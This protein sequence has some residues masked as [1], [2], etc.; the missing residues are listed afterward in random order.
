MAK[1]TKTVYDIMK[2]TDAK[3]NISAYLQ[4]YP[5]YGCPDEA[6][7]SCLLRA[8]GIIRTLT[9]GKANA[10]SKPVQRAIAAQA[11]FLL[12]HYEDEP[13]DCEEV[14]RAA[15]MELHRSGLF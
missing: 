6:I 3:G 12:Q 1:V 13:S 2:E 7:E 11:C 10:A 5:D 8:S 9:G 4:T 14:S 15:L